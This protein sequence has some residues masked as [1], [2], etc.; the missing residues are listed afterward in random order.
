MVKGLL[1]QYSED[2][3]FRL[4]FF[5][6]PLLLVKLF[7]TF[8]VAGCLT[9]AFSWDSVHCSCAPLQGRGQLQNTLQFHECEHE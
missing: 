2:A 4:S 1:S 9:V 5:N 6:F 3:C 8:T 7:S